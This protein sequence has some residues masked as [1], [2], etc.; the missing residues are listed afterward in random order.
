MARTMAAMS[1]RTVRKSPAILGCGHA[2]LPSA[3]RDASARRSKGEPPLSV[4]EV[5]FLRSFFLVTATCARDAILAPSI[6]GLRRAQLS[7]A[8]MAKNQIGSH[9]PSENPSECS[10][11]NGESLAG[12]DPEILRRTFPNFAVGPRC[13][14]L[15]SDQY[16]FL[17]FVQKRPGMGF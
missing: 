15:H 14:R 4:V 9:P 7:N 1:T 8:K 10:F 6:A 13:Q 2:L 5:F 17:V 16:Q 3:R 12:R 11:A